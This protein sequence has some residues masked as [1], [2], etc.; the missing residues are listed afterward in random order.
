[1]SEDNDRIDRILVFKH[2][3]Q[4]HRVCPVLLQRI[5]KLILRLSVRQHLRPVLLVF[6][7]V[8][9]AGVVFGLN[10]KDPA[11]GDHDVVNLA[12][13]AVFFNNDVVDNALLPRLAPSKSQFDLQ[14]PD[15]PLRLRRAPPV[16]NDVNQVKYYAD[17]YY[18]V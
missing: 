4:P 14:L 10:A 6:A 5:I 8:N 12:G 1:M 16:G 9:A 2:M 11:A 17:Q 3:R 18:A 15:L 13:L 7:S